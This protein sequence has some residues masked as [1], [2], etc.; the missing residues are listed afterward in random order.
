MTSIGY[1]RGL[2]GHN[3]V[4]S[5]SDL[6]MNLGSEEITFEWLSEWFGDIPESFEKFSFMYEVALLAKRRDVSKEDYFQWA[7]HNGRPYRVPNTMSDLR[8]YMV[9]LECAKDE[10]LSTMSE[11]IIDHY[12]HVKLP[13]HP[14]DDY[15]WDRPFQN[16][17]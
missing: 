16:I 6:G 11:N 7:L 14:C 4:L 10:V 8:R 13:H 15:D 5:R 9:H 2:D 3:V 12:V 1:Y 17:C